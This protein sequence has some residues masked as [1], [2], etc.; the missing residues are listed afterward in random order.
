MRIAFLILILL[1]TLCNTPSLIAQ[2]AHVDIND[3]EAGDHVEVKQ[4]DQ[5][6]KG[7]VTDVVNNHLIKVKYYDERFNRERESYFPE[8]RVRFADAPEPDIALPKESRAWKSANGKFTID[9]TI[10]QLDKEKVRLKRDDGKLI[11]VKLADLCEADQKFIAEWR[12]NANP[13]ENVI[14]DAKESKSPSSTTRKKRNKSGPF[15]G[16][17]TITPD[18]GDSKTLS[19]DLGE[20]PL[21]NY[22]YRPP[23]QLETAVEISNQARINMFKH[24]VVIPG[25]RMIFSTIEFS[26]DPPEISIVDIT[27]GREITTF[28]FPMGKIE[29]GDISPDGK[30]VVTYLDDVRSNRVDLWS[31]AENKLEHVKGWQ[32]PTPDKPNGFQQI[33]RAVFIGNN[34]LATADRKN[35]MF[36]WDLENDTMLLECNSVSLNGQPFRASP[37]GKHLVYAANRKVF[38]VDVERCETVSI[39]DSQQSGG[40]IAIHE[41]GCLAH[42]ANRGVTVFDSDG[43]LKNRFTLPTSIG[44]G[45]LAWFNDQ[46]VIASAGSSIYAIDTENRVILA[47]YT[48]NG[49]SLIDHKGILWNLVR[50]GDKSRVGTV[51][52]DPSVYD[53]ALPALGDELLVFRKGEAAAFDIDLPFAED[54]I[55][56]IKDHFK[57][58]LDNLNV[59]TAQE[60]DL[61]IRLSMTTGKPRKISV[62]SIFGGF[63]QP[64]FGPFGGLNRPR[65]GSGSEL[66]EVTPKTLKMEILLEDVRVYTS[67]RTLDIRGVLQTKQDET[68]QQAIDRLTKPKP[69][70]FTSMRIRNDV[71]RHPAEGA[72]AIIRIGLD[73]IESEKIPTID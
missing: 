39:L 67:S 32:H 9:A 53:A 34:R 48:I 46:I 64:G 13:F 14:G 23:V 44:S 73:G 41:N 30:Q 61:V 21:G 4:F 28:K 47:R 56:K 27:K 19:S 37:D 69:E 11:E 52:L 35:R 18:R 50:K 33:N 68:T 65:G 66:A 3:V 70:T 72:Y 38:I 49:A 10:E 57:N 58:E 29:V 22:E 51:P 7:V 55:E 45:H 25:D 5:W 42:V 12:D 16:Y 36:V 60:S 63:P 43:E 17:T 59:G 71:A 24:M 8:D 31:I 54:E 2:E 62:R 26:N 40:S 6:Q 15:D 1:C 20:Y